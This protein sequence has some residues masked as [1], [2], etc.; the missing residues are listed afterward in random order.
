MEHIQRAVAVFLCLYGY[1]FI[2]AP[3]ALESGDAGEG[4]GSLKSERSAAASPRHC[5]LP[6]DLADIPSV[7]L[8]GNLPLL[9]KSTVS[10]GDSINTGMFAVSLFFFELP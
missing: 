9:A 7:C 1:A 8:L 4:R 3:L 6:P 10:V 2:Y 5:V